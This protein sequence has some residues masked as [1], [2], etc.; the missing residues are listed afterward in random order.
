MT[1]TET[2][3]QTST[4][5]S[6]V[7]PPP[8]KSRSRRRSLIVV[9]LIVAA[10]LALLS[11]GLLSNLNYFD[12]VAQAMNQRA[13]LGTSTFR[14]EGL[15]T[16]DSIDRTSYG[17]TFYLN[18]TRAHEVYVIAHGDPP[19]LFQSNIPVVVVGHFTSLTSTV[20]DATQIVVDHTSAYIAAHP[21]RVRAPNGSVR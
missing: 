17:A 20:F 15:V 14:L 7:E 16:P 6:P 10:I 2:A 4:D 12:T 1:A 5:V 19:Q 9:A 11:Q 21:N 18:G 3:P 13:T 8:S